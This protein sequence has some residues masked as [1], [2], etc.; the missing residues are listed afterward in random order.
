MNLLL[1][2]PILLPLITAAISLLAWQRRLVQ[3]WCVL[4]FNNNGHFDKSD[5]MV[6]GGVR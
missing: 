3:R 1:V 6:R 2:F 5:K 4:W